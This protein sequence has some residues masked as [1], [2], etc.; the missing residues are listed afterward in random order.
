VTQ[1]SGRESHKEFPLLI[2]GEKKAQKFSPPA[3]GETPHPCHLSGPEMISYT[4]RHQTPSDTKHLG[5]PGGAAGAMNTKA[6]AGTERAESGLRRRNLINLGFRLRLGQRGRV[7]VRE[8]ERLRPR[9]WAACAVSDRPCRGVPARP[10]AKRRAEHSHARVV[11][12]DLQKT[13]T[14]VK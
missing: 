6:S 3:A 11:A 14:G 13:L 9:V 1:D 2:G 12:H 8:T 4:F 5:L 7:G 10:P